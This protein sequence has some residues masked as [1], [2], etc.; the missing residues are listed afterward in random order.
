MA[1]SAAKS[2]FRA[3]LT[4]WQ[5][6][7]AHSARP[8]LQRHIVHIISWNIQWGRGA[9]G[10][11]DIDRTIETLRRSG[12]A[13]IICLQEV[14]IN[15]DGL[16]GGHRE[17]VPARLAAAFPTH[18]AH[19]HGV[20]DVDDGRQGRSQFGNMILSSLPVD[21]IIRHALPFPPEPDVPGMPRGCIEAVVLTPSGPLR[22]LCT[23]LEYYGQ[24]RR[25]AQAQSLRELQIQAIERAQ[26]ASESTNK[27]GPF[28][29]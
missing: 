10:L 27:G 17:N 21:Q 6:P 12:P 24:H 18:S 11:V 15:F 8:H 1:K 13:E 28:Q 23:H 2:C 25:A 16:A 3:P 5:R 29:R 9:D 26:K 7:S 14:P 4:F 20:I 19:Y 22:I